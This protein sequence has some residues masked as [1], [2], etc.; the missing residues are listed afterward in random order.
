MANN[1]KHKV[2]RR[3]ISQ[4]VFDA[5]EAQAIDDGKRLEAVVSKKTGLTV[6]RKYLRSDRA[7]EIYRYGRY[8]QVDRLEAGTLTHRLSVK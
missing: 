4:S 1:A 6:M 5:L 3:D 8:S 7:V 2:I